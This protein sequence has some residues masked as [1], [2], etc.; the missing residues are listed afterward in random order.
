MRVFIIFQ[1]SCNFLFLILSGEPGAL[2]RATAWHEHHCE[3]VMLHYSC[4]SRLNED[5]SDNLEIHSL[6]LEG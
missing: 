2:C 6:T 1:L 3:D 4:L 5:S